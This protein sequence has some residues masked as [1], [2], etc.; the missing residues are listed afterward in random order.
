MHPSEKTTQ[1]V[2]MLNIKELMLSKSV[3]VTHILATP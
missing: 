2:L 3:F 1:S